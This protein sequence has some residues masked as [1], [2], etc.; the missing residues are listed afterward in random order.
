MTTP[1]AHHKL[2]GTLLTTIWRLAGGA[3]R[4]QSQASLRSLLRRYPFW[5]NGHRE[6]SEL[7]L[8]SDDIT[9]AYAAALSLKTLTPHD[10][11]SQG[12][13]AL[14]LGR[15]FLKHG[16][17]SQA[18][19]YLKEAESLGIRT[20][21]VIEDQAAAHILGGEFKAALELLNS[22]PT[23]DISPEAKAALSFVKT[24]V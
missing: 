11:R 23:K 5:S 4:D 8:A 2:T 6:L 1:K 13:A 20:L 17:W 19:Q 15:C 9:T 14:I 16:E 24:K 18:L 12:E 10:R 21:R 22:I 3:K 7:A